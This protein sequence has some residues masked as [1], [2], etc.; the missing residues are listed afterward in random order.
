MSARDEELRG[1]ARANGAPMTKPRL[2]VTKY[3][4]GCGECGKP[5]A[6]GDKVWYRKGRGGVTHEACYTPPPFVPPPPPVPG[7]PARVLADDPR[8]I[9]ILRNAVDAGGEPKLLAKRHVREGDVDKTIDFD[10]AF[11]HTTE[12]VHVAD[13]ETLRDLLVRLEGDPRACIIRAAPLDMNLAKLVWRRKNHRPEKHEAATFVPR[14][15]SWA[16]VDIDKWTVPVG[17]HLDVAADPIGVLTYMRALLPE[18]WRSASCVAQFSSSAALVS[19]VLQ[20]V[21]VHLWFVLSRPLADGHE[22]K[23][24]VK[25]CLDTGV[26]IDGTLMRDV[27]PHYTARPIFENGRIDPLPVRTFVLSGAPVVDLGPEPPPP[28]PKKPKA[29]APGR[30][31]PANAS[32]HRSWFLVACEHD[33]LVLGDVGAETK[34]LCPFED[35]HTTRANVVLYAPDPDKGQTL[36]F[37]C[38]PRNHCENRTQEEYRARFSP[39]AQEAANRE[40]PGPGGPTIE[41]SAALHENVDASIGALGRD[42]D[43]YSRDGTLVHWVAV[44]NTVGQAPKGT[45]VF[46]TGTPVI[47]AISASTLR[48]RLTKFA[49]FEKFDR[50]SG[51]MLATLPTQHVVD[52]VMDRGEW[53]GIRELVGIVETPIVRPDGTIV[54]TPG[55]DAETGYIYRPT[56]QFPPVPLAPTEADARA[57]L[58]ELCEVFV[59]FPYSHAS[60]WLVPVAHLLSLMTRPMIRGAVP[61]FVYDA[62]TQSSGKTKQTDA[63]S[64]IA[65]GRGASRMTWPSSE[66]ELE[67]VLGGYAMKGAANIVFDNVS[68]N[69]P[70]CGSPLD[71]VLTAEDRVELRILGRTE[72][73]ELRWRAVTAAT[74]NNVTIKGDTIS[75]VLAARLEPKE[76]RPEDR[77]ASAFRHPE[78]L[79]WVTAERCRLVRA[80]LTMV[81]A[82]VVADRPKLVSGAWRF[83]AWTPIVPQI[84]AFA[85]RGDYDVLDARLDPTEAESADPEVALLDPL[86]DALERLDPKGATAAQILTAAYAT[87]ETTDLAEAQRNGSVFNPQHAALRD[88]L[89]AAFPTRIK[90]TPNAPTIEAERLGVVLRGLKGR[91]REHTHGEACEKPCSLKGRRLLKANKGSPA[92]WAVKQF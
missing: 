82:W 36:G 63:V 40:F 9:T 79:P 68:K 75:R 20:S 84:I 76:E 55:Y 21:S 22:W 64:I 78:L 81:R 47:R 62:S 72:V 53:S 27:Q 13:V 16:L 26:K 19:T 56:A 8:C 31:R 71:K 33:G 91:V 34:I 89:A 51:E 5:Y 12:L 28:A 80:V 67:K 45:P 52:A 66:D 11:F 69:R 29:A 90:A 59:D 43:L 32:P 41:I 14:A 54:E 24:I 83:D 1:T 74:G 15:R 46:A 25:Q 48:E 39:E 65:T 3:D 70:F 38:C 85:G 17:V 58:N 44:G 73:P 57:A 88:A 6:V 77:P 23:V 10:G 61:A 42:P 30:N 50:R 18:P 2:I 7:D 86:L 4:G 87:P 92:R 37:I 49:R 60:G 35:E